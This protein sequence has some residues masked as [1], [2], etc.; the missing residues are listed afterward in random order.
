[1][2]VLKSFI[3]NCLVVVCVLSALYSCAGSGNKN[4]NKK[5]RGDVFHLTDT[6]SSSDENPKI[7]EFKAFVSKLDSTDVVSATKALDKYRELFAEQ[8]PSLCDSGFVVFQAL[9][10]SIETHLNIKCQNDTTNYEPLLLA[11]QTSIPKKLKDFQKHLVVNGFKISSNEG[12]AYIEQDRAFV[13]RNFYP[14]VTPE[15]KAYLNELLKENRE[16]FAANGAISITPSQLVDRA[17]WY[18]HFLA[19]YPDFVFI[20]NCK[21]Y[22]KAY[23]TYLLC[24]YESTSIYKNKET[25]EMSDYFVTAYNYM[26]SRYRDSEVSKLVNPYYDSLKQK[27]ASNAQSTLKNYRIKGLIYSVKW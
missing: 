3:I 2:M 1:M 9:Y 27:Q 25:Q 5:D 6:L 16:G 12:V 22:H 24:G 21:D 10:D 20:G 23:L 15:M 7:S 11:D 14:F 18:E 19:K 26:N 4:E 13:A 8:S 17:V